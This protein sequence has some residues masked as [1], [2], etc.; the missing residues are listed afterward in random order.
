MSATVAMSSQPLVLASGSPRRSTLLREA[1]IRFEVIPAD[2]PEDATPGETPLELVR[3]LATD[4]ARA[5]AA[6]IGR[7]P[8]RWVLGADTIVVIDDVAL[9]KPDD[10][11]TKEL[12]KF[13]EP[14]PAPRAHT[15]GQPI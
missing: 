4:K 10:P 5:V 1:G 14:P 11:A 8:M 9:G 3:R 12:Y 15:A 13:L 7:L 6:R 2:I